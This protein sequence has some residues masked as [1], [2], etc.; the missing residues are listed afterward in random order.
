MR[1]RHIVGTV[2]VGVLALVV[3]YVMGFRSAWQMG[4]QAEFA[5]RGVLATQMLQAMRSGKTEFVTSLLEGDVDNALLIGGDFV[6]NPARPLVPMMG[7]DAPAA[8]E[9][10]MSRTAT[11][12]KANPRPSPSGDAKLKSAIGERVDRYAK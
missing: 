10:F 11:Y 8:Y 9:Q 5:A 7:L 6:E 3:G 4:V 1:I 2:V 12:R